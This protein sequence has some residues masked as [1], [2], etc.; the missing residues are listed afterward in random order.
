MRLDVVIEQ[1]VNCDE[2]TDY[3][4]NEVDVILAVDQPQG[5]G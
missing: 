1:V 5:V 3:P 4:N 2:A